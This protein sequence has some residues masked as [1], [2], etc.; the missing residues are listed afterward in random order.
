M[1]EMGCYIGPTL[2][3][4]EPLL[5]IN[6]WV[7]IYP[8]HSHGDQGLEPGRGPTSKHALRLRY[9][10]VDNS[11]EDRSRPRR[12]PKSAPIGFTIP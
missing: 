1:A 9:E 4:S 10:N 11:F 8:H 3:L 6:Q 12:L 5:I 7:V 2:T